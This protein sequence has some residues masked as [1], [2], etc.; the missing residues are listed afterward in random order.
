M[1]SKTKMV[2]IYAHADKDFLKHKS[3]F[4]G[5]LK[6]LAEKEEWDFW[7]D[8]ELDHPLFDEEIKQQLNSADIVICLVSQDF[9]NSSYVTK[10]EAKITYKRLKEQG[11]LVVPVLL[12]ASLWEDVDWL[13]GIDHFPEEGYLR[14]SPR[15]TEI[16]VEIVKHIRKWYTNR[17]LPLSDPK[18]I[19]KLRRLPETR[20]TKEQQRQLT[21]NSC[22]RARQ[23]VPDPDLHKKISR[24]A[25]KMKRDAKVETLSK[26]ML[27]KLD[28]QFLAGNSRKPD[29]KKIRWVLR[30]HGLHPQGS[31]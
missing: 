22:E 23:M 9:L 7:W 24:A 12:S 25:R 2:M 11:I 10:V 5:F 19:D 16:Y 20:L 6:W 4:L 27:A 13:V 15:K 17:A 21:K 28:E 18:L 31:A 3:N 14:S 30:C 1:K 26:D 29:P 8:D